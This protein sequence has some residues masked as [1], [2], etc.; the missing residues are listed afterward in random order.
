MTTKKIGLIAALFAAA[1]VSPASAVSLKRGALWL[2]GD[3]TLHPYKSTATVVAIAGA[4]FKSFEVVIDA[5]GL[6]SGQAALD[7]NMYAALK[8]QEHP[9]ITFRAASYEM[10]QASVTLQGALT[11]AGVEKPVT[12]QAALELAPD[13]MRV[14]GSKELLMSDFSIK[15]PKMFLGALKVRDR[16]VVHFDV[17][18]DAEGR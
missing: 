11:V 3:S 17:T 18:L 5:Q 14:Q 6:K 7:R 10:S 1:F 9:K 15:P 13:G 16:V 12:L 2:E 8:A 4:D